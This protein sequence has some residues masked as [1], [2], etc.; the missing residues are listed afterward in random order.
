MKKYIKLFLSIPLLLISIISTISC[1]YFFMLIL[2]EF[3]R[4]SNINLFIL[5]EYTA[6]RLNLSVAE[7]YLPN[8][9]FFDN[10]NMILPLGII[11]ISINFF[12]FAAFLKLFQKNK[13]G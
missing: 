10:K 6:N 4:S 9:M 13:K 7:S 5:S 12:C 8:D 1:S 2:K 11:F 3:I